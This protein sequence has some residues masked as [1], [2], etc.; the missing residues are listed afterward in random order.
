M[1][2]RTFDVTDHRTRRVRRW[3]R[4]EQS[5][6]DFFTACDEDFFALF[7]GGEQSGEVRFRFVCGDRLHGWDN[8]R[9]VKLVK[10]THLV[11]RCALFHKRNALYLIPLWGKRCKFTVTSP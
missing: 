11:R 6:D 7:H 5:C 10:W 9:Q 2:Y 3:F 8:T 1:K 4:R